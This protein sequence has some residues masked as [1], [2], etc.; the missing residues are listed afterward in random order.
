MALTEFNIIE[1]YFSHLSKQREDV[2]L[3]IGDDCALLKPPSGE[4]LA[5]SMDTLVSGVHFFPD[6]D[7]ALLGHKALAVNLSDL[8]A[9]GAK[10]AW[11]TLALTL[12]ESDSDWLSAFSRGF[13]DLAN[14]YGVQLVGGDTTHG[15]LSITVQVHGFVS[16]EA[17]LRR[18]AAQVGDLIYVTGSLGDAGLALTALQGNAAALEFLGMIRSRLEAPE[19]RIEAGLVFAGLAS[20]GID[21]SDGLL[22]DL[23][24]I[25]ECSGVAARVERDAL[26]VSEAVSSYVRSTGDWRVA[27]AAG[28]DYELC[29]TVPQKKKDKFEEAAASLDVAVT[30]IGR[31]EAGSGVSC[32]DAY[33]ERVDLSMKGYDHFSHE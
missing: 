4:L 29:V 13:S 20:A 26:P 21:I 33:G 12:P 5:V 15:P 25:C 19:P 11:A 10:P 23:G 31:I 18:D 7:P 24:H 30:W 6:V 16:A 28:D 1:H 14:R 9:M 3:G 8:A 17:C 27:L 22:A 2:L 32:F